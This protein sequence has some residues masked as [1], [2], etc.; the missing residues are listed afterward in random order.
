MATLN[1]Q[2]GEHG[3][4]E[5][6]VKHRP[7]FYQINLR[8]PPELADEIDSALIRLNKTRSDVERISRAALFL[9]SIKDTIDAVNRRAAEREREDAAVP[10]R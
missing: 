4:P 7:L 1:D 10:T 5:L 9:A 3:R 6:P 2:G 8:I